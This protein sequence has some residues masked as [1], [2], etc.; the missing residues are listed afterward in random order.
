MRYKTVTGHNN[1]MSL[2]KWYR[3]GKRG[4]YDLRYIDL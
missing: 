2:A 4:D 3:T 1:T